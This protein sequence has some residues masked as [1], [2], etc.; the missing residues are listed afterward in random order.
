MKEPLFPLRYDDVDG[1]NYTERGTANGARLDLSTVEDEEV[2]DILGTIKDMSLRDTLLWLRR[3]DSQFSRNILVT[4]LETHTEKELEQLAAGDRPKLIIISRPLHTIKDLDEILALSNQ[5]LDDGGYIHCNSMTAVLKRLRLFSRWPWGI[6]HLLV[7]LNY[8]WHR[9]IPKLSL[10]RNLYYAV[11]GG[12]DRSF[13]RV[14]IMGRLYKAGFEVVDEQFRSGQYFI[15][16]HKE[17]PPITGFEPSISPI[18]KLLRVGKDGK[19]FVVYKFRT[20]YS[21]SAYIQPYIYEHQ[22]LQTGGKIKDDYRVDFWGKLMRP[23]WLDELPMLWNLLRGDLKLVGVRPLSQ[24]YFSLYSPEM[25]ELRVKVK[26]GLIPPFYYERQTPVTLEDVQESERRYIE[27]YLKHP[28]WTD[29]RYFW[30][31]I[32]NIIFR[33]KHSA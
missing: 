1:K 7:L 4:D 9:A 12:K 17:N 18:V 31:I 19:M 20:M 5:I 27:A 13:N 25:Q 6:A 23:I 29:W 28:F 30:G 21:Y 26:P 11:T 10:T 32:F 15:I 2:R 3:H 8:L 14:E 24:H 33:H 22:N 16:G